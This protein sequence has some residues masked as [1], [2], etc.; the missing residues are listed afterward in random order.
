MDENLSQDVQ[1]FPILTAAVLEALNEIDPDIRFD[2]LEP[3]SGTC[4]TNDTGSL[5]LTEKEFITGGFERLCSYP[6][7]I[8]HRC[9][10][11][12]EKAGLEAVGY[13]NGLSAKLCKAKFPE[14]SD[15]RKITR[16][17]PKNVYNNVV[18]PETSVLN[19]ILPVTLEY[20]HRKDY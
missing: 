8:V 6:F 1:G 9:I 2:E 7:F 3:E 4:F 11:M 17:E 12:D 10:C 20:R 15:G 19:W 16:I 5:I 13:L 14:L 18:N